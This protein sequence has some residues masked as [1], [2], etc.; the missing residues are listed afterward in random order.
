MLREGVETNRVANVLLKCSA[1]VIIKPFSDGAYALS[2]VGCR[3]EA[4]GYLINCV[5][6]CT[7][8][9]KS[10]LTGNAYASF[11][12]TSRYSVFDHVSLRLSDPVLLV[13]ATC[14]GDH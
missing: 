6:S 3:A 9:I 4:A 2:Y 10:R 11:N 14:M 13:H 12:G 8:F 7:R 5:T 1:T